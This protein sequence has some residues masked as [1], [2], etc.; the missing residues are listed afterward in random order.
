ML[1]PNTTGVTSLKLTQ[2][3]AA[4]VVALPATLA[5]FHAAAAPVVYTSQA[6]FNTAIAP[7][8]NGMDTFTT[9]TNGAVLPPS[10]VRTAGAFAYTAFEPTGLYQG[11]SADGF[12]TN[13]I[14]SNFI[15]LSGFAPSINAFGANFFGSNFFSVFIAG[16]SIEVNIFE[17]NS[18]L[19][20]ITLTATDRASFIGYRAGS[21]IASVTFRSLQNIGLWPSVDNV[22]VA[23]IPEPMTLSLVLLALLGA[24]AAS[25]RKAANS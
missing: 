23:A 6:T 24:A 8:A 1:S 25:R 10:Q 14:P 13:N 21:S 22:T 17:T 20:S 9:F 12:L 4:A 16:E 5:S 2:F 18:T 11:L 15:V 19:F 3:L 7:H